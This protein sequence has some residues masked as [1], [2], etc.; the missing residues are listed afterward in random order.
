[1]EFIKIS[2]YLSLKEIETNYWPKVCFYWQSWTKYLQNWT[3]TE[4]VD[5]GVCVSFDCYCQCFVFK[6]ELRH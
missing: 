5:I 2:E 6:K 3:G 1:M 4:N